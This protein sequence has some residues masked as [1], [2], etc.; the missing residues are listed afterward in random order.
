MKTTAT[1]LGGIDSPD[2]L[3]QGLIHRPPLLTMVQRLSYGAFK[4]S[5]C[6]PRPWSAPSEAGAAEN[7]QPNPA[8]PL[9]LHLRP[10]CALSCRSE[11]EQGF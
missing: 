4:P 11:G 7:P 6:S 8:V 5:Q 3:T 10:E 1:A 9:A 2:P